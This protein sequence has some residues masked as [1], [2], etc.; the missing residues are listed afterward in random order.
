[1]RPS[2]SSSQTGGEVKKELSVRDAGEADTEDPR[3]CMSSIDD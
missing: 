2:K 3:E 1:M